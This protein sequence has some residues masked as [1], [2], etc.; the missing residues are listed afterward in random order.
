MQKTQRPWAT[1]ILSALAL[2]VALYMEWELGR[3]PRM[4]GLSLALVLPLLVL[5]FGIDWLR[6]V[7]PS[8]ARSAFVVSLTITTLALPVA[9]AFPLGRVLILVA[10]LGFAGAAMGAHLWAYW[11]RQIVEATYVG[12][13]GH[14]SVFVDAD[15]CWALECDEAFEMRPGDPVAFRFCGEEQNQMADGPFR[16]RPQFCGRVLE[17]AQSRAALRAV[18]KR[19]ARWVSKSV[20]VAAGAGVLELA[21][22]AL[23]LMF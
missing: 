20:M 9:L 10:A 17:I 11:T 2:F 12:Q 1:I 14:R 22:C 4:A 7:R 13:R 8:L 15:S 5:G 3:A 16:T 21:V 18:R 6:L 23:F 19:R